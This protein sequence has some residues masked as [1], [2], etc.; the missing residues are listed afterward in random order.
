[1]IIY[2]ADKYKID[3]KKV[4][5]DGGSSGGETFWDEAGVDELK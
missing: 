1:M 4:F 3:P 5:V 2:A